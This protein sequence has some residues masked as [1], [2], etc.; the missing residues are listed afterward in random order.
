MLRINDRRIQTDEY[1]FTSIADIHTAFRR[2]A[3]GDVIVDCSRL[4]WLD[5]NMC[6][7]LAAAITAPGRDIRLRHVAPDIQRVLRKNGFLDE[8]IHDVV[9]IIYDNTGDPDNA[10]VKK[11]K[12]QQDAAESKCDG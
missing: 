10:D 12:K 5:A 7:P 1:G 8:R 6:A 11:G 9:I 2:E 3:P 4:E